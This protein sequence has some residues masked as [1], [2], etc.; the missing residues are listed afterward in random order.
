MQKGQ[1]VYEG[2]AKRVYECE[3][4]DAYIVEFK[5]D[6]TAFNGQKKGSITKK[7]VY[8]NAISTVFFDWLKQ[9]GIVTHYIDTL[10]EREMLVKR[11]RIIPVEVVTR[12]VA[13]GTLASRLGLI[14]GEKL[15]QT[16][17]EFYLKNDELGDPLINR[18]HAV[19]LELATRE[20]LDH[21]ERTALMINDIL[22]ER[23]HTK[24]VLLVDFK[25]EFGVT[26]EGEIV[27][28]DEISPDTCRFWDEQ[29]NEKLD[30]DRFRRDLGRVE[31]AYQEILHRIQNK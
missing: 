6:A 29:T 18:S 22:Y 14:E 19:A 15:K 9:E 16:V 3:R 26:A 13:A 7:G 8:N 10:S 2:K 31:E 21:L 5:D 30:K 12:N 25:L 20:E 23:L 17:V 1:M 28:A 27:L 11:V 4:D 24:G